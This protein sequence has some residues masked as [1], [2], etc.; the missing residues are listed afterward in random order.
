MLV[1]WI[2]RENEY[3]VKGLRL[4]IYKKLLTEEGKV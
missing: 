2:F 3:L 1:V 4:Y